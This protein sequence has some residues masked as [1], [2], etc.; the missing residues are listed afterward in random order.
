[1][2]RQLSTRVPRPCPV[3]SGFT[4]IELL[5]VI[6]I[7]AVLV[8]LL[9]PAVQ[10][11][12]EAARRTQCKNNLAQI[13]LASINYE[14]AHGV[15]PPGCVNETG[16]ITSVPAGNHLSWTYRLMPYLDQGSLFNMVN[17]AAGAYAQD[18]VI[19]DARI[20]TLLC[21]S[22]PGWP[23]GGG[24]SLSSYAGCHAG[25]ETPIHDS[26]DGTFILNTAI[27]YRGIPDGAS[28][29][30][31]HG[32]KTLT[33]ADISW[34]SG[35]RSTLRNT[36]HLPNRFPNLRPATSLR[37]GELPPEL[38][39]PLTVGGFGSHHTGGCNLAMG[40]GA[41]RFVS[42][43]INEILFSNL[44]SRNDGKFTGEF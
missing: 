41:V 13:A 24:P 6:A 32:E 38:A 37:P 33:G 35:T 28:N 23:Q 21:P 36:G 43:N 5:V 8:A 34:L 7:I 17:P 29:T 20:S 9:L 42:E 44:G 26:N 40:D 19:T 11:A 30:I 22:D 3:R 16:P 25:T 39:N 4:L 27:S 31:F 1:M 12:R 10:Q 14:M 2:Q 18:P 15:L